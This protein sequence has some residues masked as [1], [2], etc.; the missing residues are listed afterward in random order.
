MC[1]G[2]SCALSE[3]LLLRRLRPTQR[4]LTE[5]P[6]PAIPPFG[7]A[8]GW[9][10]GW[11]VLHDRQGLLGDV[12]KG[13]FA[14]TQLILG[15]NSLVVGALPAILDPPPHSPEAASLAAFQ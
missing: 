10:V 3:R 2:R 1:A 7:A 13:L 4:A 14:L 9:R 12:R 6:P 15:A 11:V 8:A 5:L